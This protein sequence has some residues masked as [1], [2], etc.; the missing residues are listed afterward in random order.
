MLVRPIQLDP[1]A[2][3]RALAD[4]GTFATCLHIICL[5][6]YG[7]EIYTWDILELLTRLEE[8]FNVRVTDDNENKLNAICMATST[9]IFYEDPEAFRGICETLANGDPGI[10]MLEN[11][12]LP[13]AVFGLYVV[14]LNHG[15]NPL[16]PGVQA[17]LDRVVNGEADDS[18]SS[19]DTEG[20]GYLFGYLEDR[21]QSLKRQLEDLGVATQGL[22]PISPE[23][24]SGTRPAMD[25]I[26]AL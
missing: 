6:Q 23:A 13:E 18:E 1:K 5:T 17:V 12:T 25:A 15:P 24:L 11:L 16:S 9:D 14:E 21:R 2:V 4:D 26:L 22:P 10:G 8:D 20:M 7:E 19:G 3:Y